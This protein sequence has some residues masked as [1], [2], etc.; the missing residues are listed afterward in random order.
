R[1]EDVLLM[2]P[3]LAEIQNGKTVLEETQILRKDGRLVPIEFSARMLPDH[4]LMAVVRD[5]TERKEAEEAWRASEERWRSVFE[6]SAIGISLT[7][8]DGRFI[9]T[10]PA[11]QQMVGYTN[12]E[13][14]SLPYTSVT[15]E[16]DRARNE[17]L[18]VE[19]LSGQRREFSLEK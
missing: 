10:N 3:V 8:L 5:V 12:E 15:L 14:R 1:P 4:R 18:R 11:Y 16:Q 19:L 17:A 6:N 7:A 9:V 2:Q 13:L